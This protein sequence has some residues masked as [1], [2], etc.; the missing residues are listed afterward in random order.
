MDD[1]EKGPDLEDLHIDLRHKLMSNWNKA[2]IKLM[3]EV[4]RHYWEEDKDDKFESL[5]ERSNDYI[6]ELVIQRLEHLRWIWRKAQPKVKEDGE[7]ECPSEIEEWMA[8]ERDNAEKETLQR[9]ISIKKDQGAKDRFIWEWL[10]HVI[11]LLGEGGMSSDESE[12]D[13]AGQVVYRVNAMPWR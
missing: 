7:V 4:V 2:I 6:Q 8:I 11:E 3:V 9:M 10:L 13:A 1:D 12:V 5:T